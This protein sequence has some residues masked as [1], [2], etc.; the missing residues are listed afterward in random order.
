MCYNL[1]MSAITY[2]V[3]DN[4]YLNI[5]NRCTNECGFCIRN[6]SRD[7]DKQ[8]QL[9]LDREPSAQEVIEAIGD[10]SRYKQI[11]FCGYG[12]PLIRLDV[13]KEVS[14]RLKEE[15]GKRRAELRIDTNGQANLFW[16]RNILPELAGLIDVISVSLDAE[17]AKKYEKLCRPAFGPQSYQAVI[18]FI[19]EAKK[20][21]PKVEVSVVDLPS[22]DSVACRRIAQE[23][24]V[25]FR[26][27][28]YYQEKYVR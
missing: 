14:R 2:Q 28:T 5:T 12:E 1:Y 23:L 15:S 27:R 8:H 18:D 3:G 25:A 10:P 9:W 13:V 24:G 4:L 17:N 21:I 26:L 19:K 7:F 11:V 6:L 16:G 20:H 22:V